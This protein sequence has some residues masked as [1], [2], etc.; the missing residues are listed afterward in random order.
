LGEGVVSVGV[1]CLLARL[2][3][4]RVECMCRHDKIDKIKEKRCKPILN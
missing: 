1:W 4:R 2:W 3:V